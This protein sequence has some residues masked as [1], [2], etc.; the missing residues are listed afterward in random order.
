MLSNTNTD[1]YSVKVYESIISSWRARLIFV[2]VYFWDIE[3]N[4][5]VFRIYT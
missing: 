1:L 4:V 2:R 5:E 3:T